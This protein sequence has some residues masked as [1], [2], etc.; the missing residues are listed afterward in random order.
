MSLTPPVLEGRRAVLVENLTD[1][2]D[3]VLGRQRLHEGHTAG[4]RDDVGTGRDRE[5]RAHLGGGHAV[6]A[7]A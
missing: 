3:H 2:V 6:G 7:A 4:E 1:D 5:Q